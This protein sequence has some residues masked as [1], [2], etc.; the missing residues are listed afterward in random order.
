MA[1]MNAA[2]WYGAKDVRIEEVDVPEVKPHQVKI[3]VKFTGICGT[4]LHEYLDGPIFIPTE[5][6]HVYSGQKAPVTLGHEFAGEIVEVGSAVTRV[7]VGDRVTVEPILAKHN[8]VGDYNLDPNLNFVGLAA[9]GGFAKYCVLDGDLV[10]K[11]PDSLSYEQAALT[12][13]AAVAVYAVRQSA[14]KAGDTAV[15]FGLGPI[16][17][18]IVEALRAAGASKIYAVELSP[19]RQA[20]AEELGA[21]VVRPEEGE[22]AVAAV[23]RLTGG[24]ADVSY[25]VTGVPVVLGQALAAVHKAGECMV[26]SIWEREASIN[27]NE[28]AIQE[29]SLKGIIAYRH[30]FPKVLEL[31]EQGYFSAD[32]LVTK[33]IKLEDI[34]Q[35]GFIEL[36]RDKVQIKILVS[37][38]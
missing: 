13:P 25:E 10:H 11:V 9:D 27:P 14:L 1:K 37:P 33:K 30:I 35:E 22:D 26:V 36:T 29:K 23:Q 6:E 38:E 3:A 21:I 28:F 31:M 24:G 19:E 4:D 5:T 18:L 17:L 32:K 16:G 7:K 34:V 15:V 2:R 8:L 20:K 12:E